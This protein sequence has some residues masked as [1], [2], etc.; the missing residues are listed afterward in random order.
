MDGCFSLRCPRPAQRDPGRPGLGRADRV[1]AGRRASRTFAR[2]VVANTGLPTGEQP[3]AEVWWRIRKAIQT[4]PKLNIGWFTQGGSCRQ[5]SDEA[6]AGYD[7]RFP[8]DEYCAGPRAMPGLVPT[9]PD[10]PASAADNLAW[11][12]L[13]VGPIPMLVAF[14]DA[15]PITGPMAAIFAR[16]MRGAQA[17]STRSCA[18]PGTLTRGRRCRTGQPRLGIPASLSVAGAGPPTPSPGDH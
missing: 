7:P 6:R 4:A 17:S 16:E 2:I 5:M 10:D 11:T 1:A 13:S 14:S 12:K 18:A 15:D 8:D 9:T 3:I